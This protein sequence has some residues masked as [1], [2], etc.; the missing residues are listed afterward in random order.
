MHIAP[1]SYIQE[2]GCFF[3]LAIETITLHVILIAGVCEMIK[4][5]RDKET[6]KIYTG[7]RSAK[8]PGN[9]QDAARRKLKMLHAAAGVAGIFQYPDQ[10][11]MADYIPME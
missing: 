4:G 8:L 3:R 6:E 10:Y 1:A 7:I 5:F 9:I 11:P 2:L